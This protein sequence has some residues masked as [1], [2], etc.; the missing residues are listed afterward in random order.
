M[1][2]SLSLSTDDTVI[3][4]AGQTAEKVKLSLQHDLTCVHEWIKANRLHWGH[5]FLYFFFFINDLPNH[6]S[7]W[8]SNLYRW[9]SYY[10]CW[11]NCW[12]GS[13]NITPTWFELCPWMDQGKSSPLRYHKNQVECYLN[14]SEIWKSNIN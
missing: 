10:M 7:K 5:F 4:C 8:K 3:I 13:T 6:L 2:L 1:S 9:H 11:T 12:G 14:I